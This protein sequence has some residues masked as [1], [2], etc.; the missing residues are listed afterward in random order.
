MDYSQR[1]LNGV[2]FGCLPLESFFNKKISL[3]LF[4]ALFEIPE[5]A[6]PKT[7]SMNKILFI[8]HLWSKHFFGSIDGHDHSDLAMD[9]TL[10]D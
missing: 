2:T 5:G 9:G 6:N 10:Y 4:S 1:K 8:F 7:N 3:Q